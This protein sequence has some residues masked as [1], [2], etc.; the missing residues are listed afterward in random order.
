MSIDPDLLAKREESWF[1]V[2]RTTKTDAG[3]S[4]TDLG[5]AYTELI[6]TFFKL[7]F[8]FGVIAGIERAKRGGPP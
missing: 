7:G 1:E 6:H 3:P 5:A 4:V 8:D 2:V